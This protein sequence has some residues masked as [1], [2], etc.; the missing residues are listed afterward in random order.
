MQVYYEHFRNKMAKP[1]NGGRIATSMG[2]PILNNKQN[3]D[4]GLLN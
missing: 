2:K 3:K 1:T 4:F